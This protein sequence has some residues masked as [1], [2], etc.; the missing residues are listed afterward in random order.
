MEQVQTPN[1]L[2]R[3]NTAIQSPAI[4]EP[5]LK[6]G[7][8][9]GGNVTKGDNQLA[10]AE[11]AE[12]QNKQAMQQLTETLTSAQSLWEKGDAEGALASMDKTLKNPSKYMRPEAAKALLQFRMERGQEYKGHKDMLTA[13][14]QVSGLTDPRQMFQTLLKGKVPPQVAK[15]YLDA[16][17]VGEGYELKSIPEMGL[18]LKWNNKTGVYE[19]LS[20]T[21]GGGSIM[22]KWSPKVVEQAAAMYGKHPSDIY[23]AS[24][25]G[26]PEAKQALLDLV[27]ATDE[28]TRTVVD[29]YVKTVSP[30]DEKTGKPLFINVNTASPEVLKA[31]LKKMNEDKIAVARAGGFAHAQGAAQAKF[32][33]IPWVESLPKGYSVRMGDNPDV[34]FDSYASLSDAKAKGARVFNDK[35]SQSLDASKEM[36]SL[37]GEWKKA[38]GTLRTERGGQN[39]ELALGG[40]AKSLLGMDSPNAAVRALGA[41]ALRIA[42]T[43]QG[44][45]QNISNADVASIESLVPQPKDSVELAEK[46]LSIMD[47]IFSAMRS[48][49]V[50]KKGYEKVKSLFE[51]NPDRKNWEKSVF[52]TSGG[53]SYP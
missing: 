35:D 21:L 15:M 41:T 11:L 22:P 32:Q 6:L 39:L 47:S 25:K 38:I 36:G 49:I 46:K 50:E 29:D 53:R 23:K 44:S 5:L 51:S 13:L 7:M 14:D 10:M 16:T 12:L 31:A 26:D 18:V 9:P 48:A 34:E 52:T 8:L 19:D 17:Q 28:R 3:M 33:T 45:A 42:K 24:L 30:K 43:M 20:Q 4:K 40:Y 1:F 37:M 2:D 27:S